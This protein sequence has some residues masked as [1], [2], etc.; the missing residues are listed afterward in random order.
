M[1]K[2]QAIDPGDICTYLLFRALFENDL[3]LPWAIVSEM[4]ALN[5]ENLLIPIADPKGSVF[6]IC[7][8]ITVTYAIEWKRKDFLAL[9]FNK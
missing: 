5:L 8:K 6:C 3:L 9:L 7:P 4:K 2:P 1:I